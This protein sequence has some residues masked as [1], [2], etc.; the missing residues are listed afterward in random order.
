MLCGTWIG[1][2]AALG[3]AA[4]FTTAAAP[5]GQGDAIANA[6]ARNSSLSA[7]TFALEGTMRMHTF[8]WLRFRIGGDG[9]FQRGARYEVRLT[10]VPFFAKAFRH[11]DLSALS[12]EMWQGRY[13]ISYAGTQGADDLYVLRDPADD[14]LRDAVVR[15][16]PV[17]GIREV[18]FQYTNGGI[19]D[20]HVHCVSQNGYLV[21]GVTDA[22]VDVPA[23]RLSVEATFSYHDLITNRN[24][25]GATPNR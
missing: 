12:P 14:T 10:H 8:P 24:P 16:D 4:A 2:A 9:V 6:Y 17:K 5:V 7:Y 19:V 21:P 1:R 15:V 11:V 22:R 23:A 25:L 13:E 3:A 18:R 20:M